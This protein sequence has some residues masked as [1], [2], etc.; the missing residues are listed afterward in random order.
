MASKG[1]LEAKVVTAPRAGGGAK[2]GMFVAPKVDDG[3]ETV[4]G[5]VEA[6]KAASPRGKAGG[7]DDT[8][9]GVVG[10]MTGMILASEGVSGERDERGA[11]GAGGA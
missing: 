1:G 4:D 5:C 6:A 10:A 11:G 7:G 9:S 8:F 2:D 3:D